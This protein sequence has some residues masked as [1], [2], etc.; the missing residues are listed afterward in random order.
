LRYALVF[1]VA[2][3][4]DEETAKAAW[5]AR[6]ETNPARAAEALQGC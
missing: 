4:F 2:H 5:A 3:L 6:V 1:K